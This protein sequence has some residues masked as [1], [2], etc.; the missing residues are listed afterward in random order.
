MRHGGA[1]L[2][3]SASAFPLRTPSSLTRSP[4]SYVRAQNT[5]IQLVPCQYVSRK[6]IRREYWEFARKNI[7]LDTGS[8]FRPVCKIDSKGI[9]VFVHS[10]PG[11][12][13]VSDFRQRSAQVL[14]L[15]SL[16]R[17]N[18]TP[19]RSI[20]EFTENLA[21]DLI[22]KFPAALET[23]ISLKPNIKK[24]YRVPNLVW[25]NC[26]F[27]KIN[28]RTKLSTV[29]HNSYKIK[30]EWHLHIPQMSESLISLKLTTIEHT[31]SAAYD[32]ISGLEPPSLPSSLN[33]VHP[34]F[35]IH[36]QIARRAEQFQSD[37]VESAALLLVQALF[38]L[39]DQQYPCKRL[40]NVRVRMEKV[41][42]RPGTY[43][44]TKR[45][46]IG[47]PIMLWN[48][49]PST[50]CIV[51]LGRQQ[52]EQSQRNLLGRDVQNG[53]HRA[54][55]ALGSNVGNRIEM[56]ESAIQEMTNRGLSV[57]RTS[58]L[59]ETKPMYLEDQETFINGACEI[60]TSLSPTDLLVQLKQIEK[61]LGRVKTV[62]NGPRTVDLDILL[63]DKERVEESHLS[64]PHKRMLEREFVLRPLCD[65][66]PD[67]IPPTPDSIATYQEI[68]EQLPTS[69]ESLSALTP[70]SNFL[71]PIL[72]QSP[73][74]STH[75]MAILNLTPDSF[76]DGGLYSS[77]D[78]EPFLNT[79]SLYKTQQHP[80]TILDIG[81]QSTRPH[82]HPISADEELSR[83][84]PTIKA[85]RRDPSFQTM[86]I[87]IDTYRASVAAEAIMAGA[88]I[89][90]D[91]S[92][93]QLDPEMLPTIARLGCTC[94]LMHMRGTPGTMN[95]LTSYPDG[96]V[97]GVGNELLERVRDAEK[98]GI[99]RWRI[100]LDPGIGFAKTQSQNLD[101]L[102]QFS[103]LRNFEGLRGFPWVVGASRKGF[104]GK[105]TGV[106]DAKE[107]T[108]GTAATVAAAVQGGA[109]VVRVHDV[110]EMGQVVA[111]ADAIWRV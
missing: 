101:L 34:T 96:V 23:I 35:A 38:Q 88:D 94:I 78:P 10:S 16:V 6:I 43:E 65:L 77:T 7:R 72:P 17:A 105:V 22:T 90:N 56:I 66:I 64:V 74:R 13:Y 30:T 76:S 55:L 53:R 83:V 39:A 61:G 44:T 50:H 57:I 67:S 49:D 9:D 103:E 85:I 81:G 32:Q 21:T 58:S 31:G 70:L 62:E 18:A 37:R 46:L 99:G 15:E 75:L 36:K 14:E 11:F 5:I 2:F 26:T 95:T 12:H 100:M 104:I 82:A 28:I 109:D 107:R 29:Q 51:Q 102:R 27:S 93:G 92:A 63:Y 19:V 33:N 59:Y 45:P 24:E 54:Y 8:P 60:E 3:T 98:A 1:F 89:I 91:V 52:Y 68:L 41:V 71:P 80:V 40:Q 69:T 106:Q 87:S 86:A 42:P 97:S 73:N 4:L 79:L 20:H 108:W 47:R 48:E 110:K 84:L 25:A 111:M